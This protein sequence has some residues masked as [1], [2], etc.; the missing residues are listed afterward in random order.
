MRSPSILRLLVPAILVTMATVAVVFLMRWQD[1]ESMLQQRLDDWMSAADSTAVLLMAN[2]V[3]TTELRNRR[4]ANAPLHFPVLTRKDFSGHNSDQGVAIDIDGLA[5]D[6]PV[7]TTDNEL[8][9]YQFGRDHLLEINQTYDPDSL[10]FSLGIV[11]DQTHLFMLFSV[12]DDRVI[13]RQ[14][15]GISAHRNDYIQLAFPEPA[16]KP[17]RLRRMTITAHQPGPATVFELS[18]TSLRAL[19]ENP[20]IHAYWA[21]TEDGY[22][23]ELALPRRLV[24][25]HLG[26][27]VTDVDDDQQRSRHYVMGPSST[28]HLHE[29]SALFT[30]IPATF[31]G[32]GHSLSS[33]TTIYDIHGYLV[34]C[35]GTCPLLMRATSNRDY[36]VALASPDEAAG[37]LGY[38]VLRQP[39]LNTSFNPRLPWLVAALL[40]IVALLFVNFGRRIRRGLVH[41]G[42]DYTST[43]AHDGHITDHKLQEDKHPIREIEEL[44]A[45]LV[46]A[47]RLLKE[48]Y[49]Y[50]QALPNRLA[51]ELRTP[52]SVV[53]SSLDNLQGGP[54]DSE[55]FVQRAR[56]G[57]ATLINL[58]QRMTEASRLEQSLEPS[59]QQAFALE[60][61]IRGLV[62]S[63]RSIHPG[64]TFEVIGIEEN[65]ADITIFGLPELIAQLLDKV[66]NN[67]V[68][69][70]AVNT[71]VRVR[72][73][74]EEGS[75]VVR[76]SNE[77]PL[78]PQGD[79][80]SPMKSSRKGEHS[81]GDMA[82]HLGLG[83]YIARMIARFHSGSI[84]AA[85]RLDTEG[86]TVT[87]ILPIARISSRI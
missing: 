84:N 5:D 36:Q 80:F 1:Q 2:P 8:P 52:V 30:P 49:D 69:F 65:K 22:R 79:P 14:L 28:R 23:V 58:I 64:T 47:N 41:L 77:G 44:R 3:I 13:Y 78:L 34:A 6:W 74:T 86:V 38:L 62:E 4:D 33:N 18:A 57:I 51:H 7:S 81:G 15:E 45:A 73:T 16:G 46:E 83:L 50:T 61:V 26:I 55:V 25:T 37:N 54:Q 82:A 85:D 67:A 53:Q 35:N 17:E 66:L 19:R 40:L 63:Y 9:P 60:D 59:E 42:R 43:V 11:A 72:L 12:V 87:L 20:D 48:H 24:G 76:I 10:R 70:A 27:N 56:D 32:L 75:A 68:D 39:D 31:A 21:A 29:Q 71:P